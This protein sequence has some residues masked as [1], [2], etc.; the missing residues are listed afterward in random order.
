MPRKKDDESQPGRAANGESSIYRGAD[1][2]WHGRVTVGVKD[3]GKPV[4]RHIQRKDRDEVV[5]EVRKLEKERDD[6]TVVKPGSK[7]WRIEKWYPHWVEEIKAPELKY[8]ALRAYRNAV[9]LHI[10]PGLGAHWMHKVQPDHFEKLY[11]KMI[12]EGYK[13]GAVHAVHRVAVTAFNDFVAR[14][15]MKHNPVPLA[16]KPRLEPEE[17]EPY[18]ED[19]V[20]LI[21][22]EALRRRNGVRFVIALALGLRQGEALGIKWDRLNRKYKS[23]RTPTQIQRHT[24]QHGCDDPHACGARWHKTELCP[25]NC[26]HKKCPPLCAPDC[27]RH[28]QYCPQRT[29]GGL[30]EV[31]VKSEAGKRGIGVPETLWGLIELHE[32]AQK[33]ERE[34]AG[35]EWREGGWMFTGPAGLP[36]DPR[37]DMEEWKDI[38][39]AA[40]VRDGRLHDARHTTATVLLILGIS[41]ENVMAV[42]GWS[43]ARMLKRYQHFV[44]QAQRA[45]ADKVEG[46]LWGNEQRG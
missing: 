39:R 37:R 23:L 6:G 8:T 25:S 12:A 31:S 16:K 11:K 38:L 36:I 30:V 45:V 19:E 22:R 7:H 10:V 17:I 35:S 33:T 27:A 18:D 40:G 3:D 24:W 2:Y 34:F 21:I 4:R 14:G 46:Y 44:Q 15:Y 43:D 29:G 1:G 32:A 28:G 41:N 42:M 20:E 5:K 26:R 9:Y 13:P